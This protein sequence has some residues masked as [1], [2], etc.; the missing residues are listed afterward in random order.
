VA[1]IR[2]QVTTIT[3]LSD[4]R[5]KT[6]IRPLDLGLD[7]IDK[8]EPVWFEWNMRDGGK[9]GGTEGGFIAQQLQAAQ[10]EHGAEAL[11]LVFDANPDRLE[12][13]PG[14]LLP[15]VV[16]ALQEV[17]ARLRALEGN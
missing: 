5:D 7:F 2:A 1:T 4:E 14:K 6:N 3:A 9:V 17:S 16:K 10:A 11:G 13:T 12:A 15:V 8:V